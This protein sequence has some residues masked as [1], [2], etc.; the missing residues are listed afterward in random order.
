M[1]LFSKYLVI[2]IPLFLLIFKNNHDKNSFI[3]EKKN[4]NN[5][6]KR[7]KGI[8][9]IGNDEIECNTHTFIGKF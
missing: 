3:T 2:T 6:E 7:T 1:D 8:L 9:N 4:V 5:T